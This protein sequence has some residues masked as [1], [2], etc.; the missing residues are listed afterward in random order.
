MSVE[1]EKLQ[2]LN[3]DTTK[4][5]SNKALL[6]SDE[7]NIIQERIIKNTGITRQ[8]TLR[9][10]LSL[11]Q[12]LLTLPGTDPLTI[13]MICASSASTI[14]PALTSVV[15]PVATLLTTLSTPLFVIGIIGLIQQGITMGLGSSE[16]RL[17][18]PIVIILHQKILCAVEGINIDD[19]Y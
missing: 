12:T 13:T 5:A 10:S 19:Y 15:A 2:Q 9:Y 18:A 4:T 16:G 8:E 17:F 3:K 11:T 6:D 7:M 1:E 14:V